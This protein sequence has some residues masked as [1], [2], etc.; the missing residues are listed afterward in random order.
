MPR[1]DSS[2]ELSPASELRAQ[3]TD[4]DIYEIGRRIAVA[5]PKRVFEYGTSKCTPRIT[6]EDFEKRE[7]ARCEGNRLIRKSRY[8]CSEIEREC[9]DPQNINLRLAPASS[10]DRG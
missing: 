4:V 10:R 8:A 1:T 7:L 9:A 3:P 6:H 2:I 5:I